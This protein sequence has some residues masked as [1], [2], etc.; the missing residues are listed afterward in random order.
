[1]SAISWVLEATDAALVDG[2]ESLCTGVSGCVLVSVSVGVSLSMETATLGAKLS[3]V[4]RK[5][6]LA[7]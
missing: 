2:S 4:K 5:R 7:T 1:M 6:A 3:L